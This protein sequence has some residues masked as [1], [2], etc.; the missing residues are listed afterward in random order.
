MAQEETL[1]LSLNFILIMK[2]DEAQ[3]VSVNPHIIVLL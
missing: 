1:F 2:I 3:P